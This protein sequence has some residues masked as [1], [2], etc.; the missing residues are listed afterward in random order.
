MLYA[1]QKYLQYEDLETLGLA[2][3]SDW[4]GMYAKQDTNF[5][6]DVDT[7]N[8]RIVSR[9]SRFH[10]V[11]ELT[12]LF[13]QVVDF[14]QMSQDGIPKRNGREDCVI[15]ETPEFRQFLEEIS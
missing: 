6:I 4:V 2:D 5:E 3:F 1:F 10:N 11:P 9:L 13:S 8:F 12:A 7:S 15:P 14:H